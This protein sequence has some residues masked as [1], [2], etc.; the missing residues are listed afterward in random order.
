M[1]NDDI[2]ASLAGVGYNGP[3]SNAL[4]DYMHDTYVHRRVAINDMY[5]QVMEEEGYTRFPDFWYNL[6][7]IISGK[8][9]FEPME[10]YP[11][12]SV[13]AGTEPT[14]TIWRASDSTLIQTKSQPSWALIGWAPLF[15]FEDGAV[16]ATLGYIEQDD[17]D[18]AGGAATAPVGLRVSSS[19][20]GVFWKTNAG[21]L[22]VIEREGATRNILY[23]APAPLE[24]TVIRLEV[25]GD[26]VTLDVAG[27]EVFRGTTIHTGEGYGAIFLG[28][29][30]QSN[31]ELVSNL[32]VEAGGYYAPMETHPDYSILF[33][34][35][36]SRFEYNDIT[37]EL[38]IGGGATPET[39]VVNS[40]VGETNVANFR[41]YISQVIPNAGV[42]SFSACAHIQDNGYFV[43]L[44]TYS[45]RLELGQ[46][47]TAPLYYEP[48]A[49]GD[50][51]E[52][53]VENDNA[54]LIHND[55]INQY[56][57]DQS[58]GYVGCVN[59]QSTHGRFKQW[60]GW[61]WTFDPQR[62]YDPIE[63]SPDWELIHSSGVTQSHLKIVGTIVYNKDN[64]GSGT[65]LVVNNAIP[66]FTNGYVDFQWRNSDRP[67]S[68][69]GGL[70]LVLRTVD[71][72]NM[73]G[74]NIRNDTNR[75][76]F[77]GRANGSWT[78]IGTTVRPIN[79][80]YVR[81]SAQGDEY[82]ITITRAG[83]VIDSQVFNY[84]AGTKA[85]KVGI[86][87]ARI[88]SNM[89]DQPVFSNLTWRDYDT[90]SGG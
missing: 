6:P 44:R 26:S 27:S 59:R 8:D 3:I 22:Q 50:Y 53:L 29:I 72:N 86:W 12:W 51:I 4:Y 69:P 63:S 14:S 74:F 90:G 87:N 15:Q 70:D 47:G 88:A 17:I 36:Q 61:H 54:I 37:E 2:R 18:G 43:G 31:V 67:T 21:N 41:G 52:L 77:F 5:K 10:R 71:Q 7:A 49:V 73:V 35:T 56:K 82:T 84:A 83:Q 16:N 64:I 9:T 33:G 40:T 23:E 85:G 13:I 78:T 79:G 57:L 38:F 28:E 11:L 32:S 42:T 45:G 80:D 19:G 25:L 55:K 75:L 30:S 39:A 24:G 68:T 1:I 20:D 89:V 48:C 65:A 46:I 66:E 34:R 60:D 58:S 76:T 81:I 62:L